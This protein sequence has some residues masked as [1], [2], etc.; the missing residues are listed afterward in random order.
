MQYSWL[1]KKYKA[2]ARH[3]KTKYNSPQNTITFKKTPFRKGK[4]NTPPQGEK[5]YHLQS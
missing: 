3:T 2:G 1:K 5:A 4:G